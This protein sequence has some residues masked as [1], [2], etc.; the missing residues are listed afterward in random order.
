MSDAPNSNKS[1][2]K[3]RGHRYPTVRSVIHI[4]D[5]IIALSGGLPGVKDA[6]LLESA[7][8]KAVQSIGGDDAYPTLFEKAAVVGFSIAQNHVF[9]DAN[10]RTALTVMLAILELNGYKFK[11]EQQAA[12]TVMVLIATGNLGIPGVR[13]ALLHWAGLNPGDDTL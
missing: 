12:T 2:F 11:L 13:V 4:H 10:K 3:H 9:N 6:G 5:E 8:R 7:V 1:V